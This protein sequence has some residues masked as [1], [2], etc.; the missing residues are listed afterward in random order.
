MGVERLALIEEWPVEFAAAAVVTDDGVVG[1]RGDEDRVVP[2]ASVTK[3]LVSYGV[4]LAVEEGAIAL[5]QP[6]GPPGATVRHL[7]AHASGLAFGERNSVAEPGAKRIYSSAGF[8]VLAE[9]IEN[10]TNIRFADYLSEGVLAPL[11]MSRT[12]L[13]GPAG[14]GAESSLADLSAFARELLS[15]GLLAPETWR[16]A[17]QVVFPGLDGIVPGYGR[18]RPCDWGLGFE[19]RGDKRPHWTGARNTSATFGH[20]GQSGTFLWADPGPRISLIVLTNRD[21]GEWAKPRWP[22][23]S[24]AVV[25]EIAKK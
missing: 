15:P 4:L 3:L 19:L 21:F 7:L 9:L 5:E 12:R 11:G 6:A 24:D 1:S 2:L 10:E 20:F 25:E 22:E 16:A 17:T 23:L 14:H 13:V 8:E 18:Q